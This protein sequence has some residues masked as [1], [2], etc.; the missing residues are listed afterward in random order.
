MRYQRISAD[1]HIDLP[2][3]PPDLF[4]ANAS[5]ALKDRMPYVTDGPDGPYWT[6]KNGT[7]FGLWG[8]VG[9]AG[10]KYIPGQHHRVDV[11]AATGLYDDG[12]KGI[13]RPTDPARRA[14]DMDRD[15]VQAE[16]IYGILG[17][18]TR[19]NDHEAATEMFHI[20]NDWLVEFC[21][22]DPD[23]FI[24]LACLPYGDIAAAVQ[25]IYRVSKLGLRGMELSCSWDMEPM[26][27]PVWEPLWRAVNDVNLPLHFH[28]FPAL[29]PSVL[30]NQKGLTRRAA[31]FTVV[32]AFQMNLVNI[33]AAIIGA[34]VLE[35][36]PNVRIAFGESGIGWVPYALDR[37][38]FEWEDRFHDLG[39]T[40]KPSDYWRRQCK[41]TFQFDRIGTK[42]IDDMGV[43]TL[44]WGSDYP[45]GDGVWPDSTKYI[46]EQ[47]GHLPADVTYKI[48]CENAGRFYGLIK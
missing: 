18:A 38:D 13:A 7:S 5:A 15:G 6:A 22:H 41:A 19:L 17:A 23:R 33:L 24:G 34:A 26:W 32:S 44:M 8:G 39:L 1:C 30:E 2:W 12:R 9:P 28:T 45:H 47:F 29:P 35:R 31:F 36:Y 25:E 27:H 37:M 14:K 10:S 43:E 40:M 11:M 3:I 20:Y 42:L 16:V 21:R 4:T 48:T 46:A